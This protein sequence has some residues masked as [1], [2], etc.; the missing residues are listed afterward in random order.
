MYDVVIIH[1]TYGSP[2]ENWFGSLYEELTEAG[3]CYESVLRLENS[4]SLC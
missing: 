3:A 4:Y 2:F 1:G